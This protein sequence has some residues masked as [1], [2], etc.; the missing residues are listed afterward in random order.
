V[1]GRAGIRRPAAVVWAALV[2][3]SLLTGCG[4]SRPRSTQASLSVSPVHPQIHSAITFGFTAPVASG[5]HGKNQI[6]YS[7]SVTGPVGAGC[8]SAHEAAPPSVARGAHTTVTVG[9]AQLG[10]PW[11]AGAYTA[12][13]IE[14]RSAHCTGSA[15]CPQYVAVVGIVARA[16]FTV[17]RS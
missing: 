7:L 1:T 5:V 10:K 6:S 16:H 17:R 2:A 15:P 3:A 9:P 12:R 4:S 11:C 8:T 14:L 13:V